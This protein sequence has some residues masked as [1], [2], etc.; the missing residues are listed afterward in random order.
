MHPPSPDPTTGRD[1]RDETLGSRLDQLLES[2]A[3]GDPPPAAADADPE[4]AELRAVVESLHLLSRKLAGDETV[5]LPVS[6]PGSTLVQAGPDG[7]TDGGTPPA[8]TDRGTPPRL[9]KFEIVRPLGRSGQASTYLA[10]DPDLS[11]QVVLKLFHK[12]RT[13]DAQETVLREGK[14]LARVRSP[15]VAQCYSAER[16]DGIPYLV[17]EYV[18]GPTLAER[19]RTRPFTLDE[20]L[21]LAEGLAEGLAAVHAC[22]LLHR[23]VKPANVLLGD[24]GRPRLIDFGL[25]APVAS[26]AL[27]GVSGT[28]AYMAPE[29]A[30]G[31]GERVDAR[32]DVFGLGALLYTL[33]TGRPPYGGPN[34]QAVLDAA[35]AGEVVPPDR[36]DPRLPRA[37]SELCMRCLARDPADRFG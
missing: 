4:L 28:P 14:A 30:R 8:G 36:I 5:S 37:V 13:P 11:R 26:D 29:Q 21:E 31:Q 6:A 1:E 10:F 17:V 32:T 18:P 9:N 33:L 12:A 22:G 16:H 27:Q 3:H 35:R 19:Q 23:D 20:G 15:Y 2:F 34:L 7:S 24:D 25:A